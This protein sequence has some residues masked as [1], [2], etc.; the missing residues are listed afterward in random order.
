MM[1]LRGSATQT[2]VLEVAEEV[3][4][5]IAKLKKDMEAPYINE[6]ISEAMR[7]ATAVGINGTPAFVLGEE[8]I[9]GA[10]GLD[11]LKR[12]IAEIRA[13]AS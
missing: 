1:Q 4:L 10:V 6:Q 3:G 8:V 11:E 13:A 5:D 9:G 2:S 7:L 12:R